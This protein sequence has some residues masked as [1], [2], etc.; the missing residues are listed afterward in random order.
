MKI[1]TITCHDVYNVGASLQ[2]YAL[3]T[4]LQNENH[5]VEIIDYKPDYL[6]NHYSFTSVGNPKYNLPI[7]RVLYIMAKFPGRL[8]AKIGKRKKNFDCFRDQYLKL[9]EKRY[10]SCQDLADDLPD[11]DV[12][13]AG[14]DQIWNPLFNNGK[15]PSFFLSFVPDD[16]TK[17]SYA[18]SF[19]LNS[20]DSDSKHF[21]KP[22]LK[23]L[24]K[25][26]VRE[27]SGINILENM[28]LQGICVCDPVFLLNSNEWKSLA[29]P[30]RKKNYILIY[31][32]DF[33]PEIYD[34]VKEYSEKN[35]LEIVSVY[36]KS[37]LYYERKFGP[38]EFLGMVNNADLVVTNSFHACA[39]SIIFHIPFIAFSRKESLNSRIID[40]LDDVKLLSLYNTDIS[41]KV[42]RIDWSKVDTQI[43]L[44]KEKSKEYLNSCINISKEP[45]NE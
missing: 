21:M 25:I 2:A 15:D 7:V 1:K 36:K 29:I 18:A 33:N 41:E 31:D 16:K 28:G 14:S 30:Y 3:Q 40:L 42:L 22:L 43:E 4:Y 27:K 24:D 44:L 9:T 10:H 11:A 34:S 5:D 8:K 12:Y 35:D 19:T 23:R 6:S 20:I 17:V 37:N 45:F 39:F 38:R 26:S 32:F 13:I